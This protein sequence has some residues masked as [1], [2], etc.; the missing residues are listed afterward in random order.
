MS[1][2]CSQTPKRRQQTSTQLAAKAMMA[3]QAV[4]A[5]AA[6]VAMVAMVAMV[7]AARD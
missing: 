5:A 3:P 2:T 7:M 4:T 6:K 1:V